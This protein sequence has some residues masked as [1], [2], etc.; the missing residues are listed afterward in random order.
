MRSRLPG[1]IL[2]GPKTGF[3]V[4]Y[5]DWLKGSLHEFAR[6]AILDQRFLHRFGAN[7][8][9]LERALNQH[10]SGERNRGFLLW[11]MMQ[12]SLWSAQY[13]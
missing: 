6:A 3:G 13:L 8:E 10:R 9:Y 2:D 5:E 12:L 4:P 11:K 7:P 1:E